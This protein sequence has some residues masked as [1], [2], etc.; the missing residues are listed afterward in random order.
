MKAMKAIKTTKNN[1]KSNGIS[2]ISSLS[3]TLGDFVTLNTGIVVLIEDI[4]KDGVYFYGSD[5][6][7]TDYFFE[8][9]QIAAKNP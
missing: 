6:N 8:R 1:E 7:G 2:G 9:N 5:D 3:L 4:C